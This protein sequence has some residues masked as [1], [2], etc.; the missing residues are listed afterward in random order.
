MQCDIL[1]CEFNSW[2]DEPKRHSEYTCRAMGVKV[3]RATTNKSTGDI[4]MDRNGYPVL[5]CKNF[6]ARLYKRKT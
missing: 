6:R 1:P 5:V 2:T 4:L 3:L